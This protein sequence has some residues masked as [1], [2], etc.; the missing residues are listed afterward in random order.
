M[1]SYSLVVVVVVVRLMDG[2]Y[3]VS[4]R[5][6]VERGGGLYTRPSQRIESLGEIKRC[7]HLLVQ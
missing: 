2:K 3:S 1:V 5:S 7:K 4:R 6:G